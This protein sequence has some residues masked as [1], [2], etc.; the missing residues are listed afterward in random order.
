MSVDESLMCSFQILKATKKKKWLRKLIMNKSNTFLINEFIY[1]L[2]T[3]LILSQIRINLNFI[4]NWKIKQ[5]NQLLIYWTLLLL[6]IS[7][8]F[9]TETLWIYVI[10]YLIQFSFWTFST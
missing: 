5:K 6:N 3:S 4:F 1:Y 7:L 10:N 9:L 8:A 2:K